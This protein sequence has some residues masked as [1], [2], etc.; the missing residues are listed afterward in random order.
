MLLAQ[1][2][3]ETPYLQHVLAAYEHL[4]AAHLLPHAE[5]IMELMARRP[6]VHER[7][8]S[9]PLRLSRRLP[10]ATLD[11][12]IDRVA[13]DLQ[14]DLTAPAPTY[15]PGPYGEEFRCG[16][17][18]NALASL[19]GPTL[20][21]RLP[22]LPWYLGLIEEALTRSGP[23]YN[24][25]AN[26][27]PHLDTQYSAGALLA[28]LWEH[29]HGARPEDVLQL[30]RGLG[31]HGG[32]RQ[33]ILLSALPAQALAPAMPLLLGHA[34]SQADGDTWWRRDLAVRAMRHPAAWDKGASAAAREALCSA[35]LAALKRLRKV[36]R[37]APSALPSS[38]PPHT[39]ALRA[40]CKSPVPR[41]TAHPLNHD[42]PCADACPPLRR[43][44]H[45]ARPYPP[46]FSR[47]SRRCS[48]TPRTPSASLQWTSSCP[49]GRSWLRGGPAAGPTAGARRLRARAGPPLLSLVWASRPSGRSSHASRHA[50]GCW[51]PS[52][53]PP[54]RGG[55]RRRRRPG[56][57][58]LLG[59]SCMLGRVRRIGSGAGGL[60][61]PS[62]MGWGGGRWAAGGT[63][64][65]RGGGARGWWRQVGEGGG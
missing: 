44:S 57:V 24:W 15:W 21:R 65:G 10:E 16:A 38:T 54:P 51:P 49:Q 26:A 31:E 20:V 43:R 17:L 41:T 52:G 46:A 11:A 56:W 9:L 35:P 3:P 5:R 47:P 59:R 28:R 4:P 6:F 39:C 34:L 19:P 40:A 23:G 25:G 60:S 61:L 29:G 8:A 64:V 2:R 7:G 62:T 30:A 37:Q 50:G 18:A 48:G 33:E 14:A 45:G 63:G 42:R 53:S 58:G 22:C 13:A 1:A 27:P 36:R 32:W 55:R 12:Y